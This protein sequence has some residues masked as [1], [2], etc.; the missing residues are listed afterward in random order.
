MAFLRGC[1]NSEHFRNVFLLNSCFNLLSCQL[2]CFNPQHYTHW[3]DKHFQ[4]WGGHK[5]QILPMSGENQEFPKREV[6]RIE[7]KQINWALESSTGRR[8]ERKQLLHSRGKFRSRQQVLECGSKDIFPEELL[9]QGGESKA[10]Q[11]RCHWLWLFLMNPARSRFLGMQCLLQELL[12]H[13]KTHPT[14]CKKRMNQLPARNG[15]FWVPEWG[16]QREIQ[17]L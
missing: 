3:K 17:G 8:M 1:W 14:G 6:S 15:T 16:K 9:G 11:R 13:R 10:V 12:K 7:L 4:V 2:G 5:P